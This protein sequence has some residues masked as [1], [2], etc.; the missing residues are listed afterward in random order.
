[1]CDSDMSMEEIGEAPVTPGKM[2]QIAFTVLLCLHHHH[3]F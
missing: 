3:Q 2:E 1:M